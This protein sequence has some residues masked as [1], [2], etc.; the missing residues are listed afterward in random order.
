M[1]G[2]WK[3]IGRDYRYFNNLGV[4]WSDP[5]CGA[6]ADRLISM[7]IFRIF[8]YIPEL[9][10]LINNIILIRTDTVFD[11]SQKAKECWNNNIWGI[12]G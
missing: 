3:K 1:W 5:D 6:G 7:K 9:K 2:E 11:F 4:R 8:Y 12:L 10:Y